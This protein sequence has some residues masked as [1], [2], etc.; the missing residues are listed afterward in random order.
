MRMTS[1]VKSLALVAAFSVMAATLPG[2]IVKAATPDPAHAGHSTPADTTAA[3]QVTPG[4]GT[5]S[6]SI[7]PDLDLWQPVSPPNSTP[8][9]VPDTSHPVT[10]PVS[11]NPVHIADRFADIANHWAKVD[12][13][14][15]SS[16]G[17]INGVGNGRFDPDRAVTRAELVK[18]LVTAA[19]KPGSTLSTGPKAPDLSKV[20]PK[21]W[22]YPYVMSAASAGIITA[23][24]GRFEPDAHAT[25]ELFAA[26]TVR[27][28]GKESLALAT[29]SAAEAFRDYQQISPWARGYVGM[30]KELGIMQGYS[31]M[32]VP[33]APVTRAEAA[34]MIMRLLKLDMTPPTVSVSANGP[35]AVTLKFAEPVDRSSAE[36]PANYEIGGLQV[37]AAR[38][39]LDGT[40]V[41]LSTARP[42][43]G[44]LYTM[45]VKNVR[46]V[47]WNLMAPVMLRL[48][49][50]Q[51][52]VPGKPVYKDAAHIT[53][54]F[55][56]EL[57]T[58]A[59]VQVKVVNKATGR[60]YGSPYGAEAEGKNLTVMLSAEMAPGATYV[61]SLAG[62]RD[63]AGT[64][65]VPA[66]LELS[67]STTVGPPTVTKVT[68][69]GPNT[70]VVDFS[71]PLT[72]PGTYSAAGLLSATPAFVGTSKSQVRVTVIT[73][74]P[75]GRLADQVVYPVS[76]RN[77]VDTQG[78][79]M[80]DTIRQVTYSRE[81]VPPAIQTVRAVGPAAV[82]V[83][84][85]EPVDEWNAE[86]QA[87]YTLVRENTA[88]FLN[89]SD[90]RPPSLSQDKRTLRLY[91]EDGTEFASGGRYVLSA[92]GVVDLS[93]N[94]MQLVHK[95]FTYTATQ[96]SGQLPVAVDQEAS[97]VTGGNTVQVVFTRPVDPATA[98]STGN[99][100]LTDA[101]DLAARLTV[102]SADIDPT[103]SSGRTVHLVTGPIGSDL[104]LTVRGLKDT[105]GT[106]LVPTV[107][108]L[109]RGS[110]DW[111]GVVA[112]RS[113]NDRVE[114]VLDQSAPNVPEV[115]VFRT[116][117]ELPGPIT[118]V[119]L[120]N[121]GQTIVVPYDFTA[122]GANGFGRQHTVRLAGG[123]LVPTNWTFTPINDTTAPTLTS[124]T[125]LDRNRVAVKF[126][127]DV[128]V[129]PNGISIGALTLVAETEG[130]ASTWVF[131][132]PDVDGASGHQDYL[133]LASQQTLAIA[134]GA[135][136][137][138]NGLV[139]AGAVQRSVTIVSDTTRPAV[140]SITATGA[141]TFRVV[142]TEPVELN[143]GGFQVA[144]VGTALPVTVL[145]TDLVN[146]DTVILTLDLVPS[147]IPEDLVLSVSGDIVDLAVM[148]NSVGSATQR[149]RT[150]KLVT[151]T[152]EMI[153]LSN[154]VSAG[155][156]EIIVTDY[157]TGQQ[158]RIQGETRA[159]EANAYVLVFV[160][161][162]LR[163]V[164]RATATGAFGPI[165][166]G[167]FDSPRTVEVV[168]V[169]AEGNTAATSTYVGFSR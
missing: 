150:L 29:I 1:L 3:P 111:Y 80:P 135:V 154:E 142:F 145:S 83:V 40:T 99:Y 71:K 96:A 155:R 44:Q 70:F 92:T 7:P 13:E 61:I 103:D 66:E 55:D 97:R 85:S 48:S 130:P 46:D 151:Q 147:A 12:I 65:M 160:D 141:N 165:P 101:A 118:G 169:D 89:W 148:P 5:Q 43:P 15:L 11:G 45:R 94:V 34:A 20:S 98:R 133:P 88:L 63:K 33:Q 14:A 59:P 79:S 119:T 166:F 100:L 117:S 109:M 137:D 37:T 74:E 67:V 125:G 24:D 168:A 113:F 27:T 116:G 64:E 8:S 49:I 107:M 19:P 167:D 138:R 28:A 17:V 36:N 32:I 41:V 162:T 54:P 21:A 57:A 106:S 143:G 115:R 159:V 22:Y 152:P 157:P 131:S 77:V 31:G 18:L 139:L 112:V 72:A 39:Q 6:Q 68:V 129:Q 161:G 56:R 102:H 2:P 163:A 78:K 52:P 110:S 134:A 38:L 132:I 30:A 156:T 121:N 164:T 149:F 69:T 136:T 4:A 23:V 84:F 105:S 53:I 114:L 93:G 122:Q 62:V 16:R 140:K 50:A 26:M 128:N 60:P 127:E 104:R 58:Q 86:A 75:D 82:E 120:A 108:T 47:F 73:T 126:S 87:N 95:S 9:A 81:K 51:G 10:Q 90:S 153:Y 123:G 144:R 91:L 76:I 146:P 158:D 35:T 124:V 25:R 42:V